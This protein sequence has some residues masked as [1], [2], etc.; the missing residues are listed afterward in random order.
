MVAIV[1][2]PASHSS[3]LI[4]YWIYK[5]F[6]SFVI[7]LMLRTHQTRPTRQI[8]PPKKLHYVELGVS[9]DLRRSLR[10]ILLEY[11]TEIVDFLDDKTDIQLNLNKKTDLEDKIYGR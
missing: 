1:V 5:V 8:I 6:K 2:F 7:D 9:H 4:Y 10:D 11:Y 3:L